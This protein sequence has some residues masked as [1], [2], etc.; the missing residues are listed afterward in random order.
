MPKELCVIITSSAT[1]GRPTDLILSPNWLPEGRQSGMPPILKGGTQHIMRGYFR[2]LD[3]ISPVL[4][5]QQLMVKGIQRMGP[6]RD[7]PGD[8]DILDHLSPTIQRTAIGVT[9][10]PPLIDGEIGTA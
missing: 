6:A 3:G 8:K 1:V 5:G 2:L 10:N 4:N 9:H 7:I